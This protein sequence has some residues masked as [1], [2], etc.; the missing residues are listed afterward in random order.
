MSLYHE[1]KRRNVFRVAI[2]YLALAWVVTEVASTLFPTFGIPDWGLRFLVIMFALG[3]VPALIISWVYEITPEGLKREKDVVRDASITRLTAKRLDMFTIG[4]IVVALAFILADRL[5]LS[6]RINQQSAVS[7]EVATGTLQVPQ[8]DESQYPTNSV[9][10]LPFANMS[11]DENT[12]YFSD[13]L[14]DTL[15][16]MLAQVPGLRVPARTSSFKFRDYA[17]DISEIGDTLNVGAVL[18][19]SVQLY[20][21]KI[22]VMTQLIDT[23]TGY[24]LWSGNYD[25]NLSDVFAVQDTI[26][27]AVVSALR[28]T[29]L[30]ETQERLDQ[31]R[32]ENVEAYTEYL[33]GIDN[34]N[35]ST[36]ESL[37]RAAAHMQKAIELDPGYAQAYSTLGSIYLS[38]MNY[39][40]IGYTEGKA[41]AKEAA[42]R[43]LEIAPESSE[44]LAVLGYVELSD[45]NQETAGQLLQK[46][47]ENGPNDV[48]ALTY[49]GIRVQSQLRYAEAGDIFQRALD[50]DP[51]DDTSYWRLAGSLFFQKRFPEAQELYARWRK[52]IPESVNLSGFKATGYALQGKYA[53]ALQTM[54]TNPV[55]D[56]RDP[57]IP[58]N[59]AWQ[60]LLMDMP[61]EAREWF[62]K[63]IEVNPGHSVSLVAPLWLNFYQQQNEEESVR[64]A[65]ELLANRIEWRRGAVPVVVFALLEHAAKSGQYEIL[66]ELL[67]N[68]YPNLFDDPP[69]DVER[70]WYAA[71]MVG[72]ALVQSGDTDRGRHLLRAYL[73]YHDLA[74][75]ALGPDWKSVAARL[76]LGE[77]A[78]AISTFRE[79]ARVNK[80]FW[81]NIYSVPYGILSQVM[82]KHSVMFDPIRNEP[83]FIEL[84]ELYETNAAEQRR[85]VQEMGIH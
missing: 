9:A 55:D 6:P 42:T 40:S 28:L 85:L 34:M 59:I 47:I 80:W 77:K 65:R 66:L 31:T 29:L 35:P 57:E 26:A 84:L 14:A 19:G 82:L 2:A 4:L 51:L 7:A 63:A 36:T 43:A 54:L 78:E 73:E 22:R 81:Q 24:H 62:D 76:A 68:L 39:G 23:R 5:W 74:D 50:L 45:N 83:E 52:A 13:G 71:F 32:S 56:P 33:L 79:L 37:E 48:L 18:E 61:D 30:D 58:A 11:A 8:P 41:R 1:L 70:S 15:L 38:M 67:D 21:E 17:G 64:L 53:A 3:L 10:V 69:Y 49:Y 12:A 20:G 60:Y 25:Q 75:E 46:A 27:R 72:L 44:A 16:H